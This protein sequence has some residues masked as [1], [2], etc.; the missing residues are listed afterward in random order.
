MTRILSVHPQH[1]EPERIAS[2]ASIIRAGGLVAFPTETVYGLGADG[3]NATAVK[4]IF[5]AKQRPASDPLILHLAE[6]GWLERVSVLDGLEGVV[7]AL[8]ERFWPGPLTLVLP[9]QPHV[10]LEV[11]ANGPS[12]AVRVPAHPVALALIRAAGTPIAAPSANLFGRPSPTTAQ[13][14]LEDLQDRVDVVLDGGPTMIG[15]ESTVLDV[16]PV[17]EGGV[18]VVLRHG[19]VTLE[20]L[21]TVLGEVALPGEWIVPDDESAPA[22]GMLLKHYSPRAKL[23][24]LMGA[25]GRRLEQALRDTAQQ[26]LGRGERLGLLLPDFSLKALEHVQAER[27]ALGVDIPS[28]ASKLFRGMRVLDRSGVSTI[29][30]HGFPNDGLGRALNDRLFRAAEGQT[31]WVGDEA[32]QA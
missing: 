27:F 1:P 16:R 5:T 22:P 30:T 28:V 8:A 31:V 6:P 20:T 24:V 4:R 29:L 19:G 11:T 17:L 10:P 21:T 18:P 15:L 3:L 32:S 2:A 12:V 13:D 14:V 9:R 26:A 25:S 7:A 23:M